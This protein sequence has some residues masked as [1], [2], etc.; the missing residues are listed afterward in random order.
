MSSDRD[1]LIDTDIE[2]WEEGDE[3][4]SS[5]ILDKVLDSRRM[6]ENKLEDL[7]LARELSDYN[8]SF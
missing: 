6:V 3:S 4:T 2:D 8:Y 7:R 1:D 5:L